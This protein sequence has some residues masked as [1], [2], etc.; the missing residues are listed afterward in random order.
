MNIMRKICQIF[1]NWTRQACA[2]LGLTLLLLMSVSGSA[3]AIDFGLERMLSPGELSEAHKKFDGDCKACHSSFKDQNQNPLCLDCHKEV[4]ADLKNNLG[5]HA[6]KPGI[7]TSECRLCHSEH[8]GRNADIVQL[9][10][11]VFDHGSTDFQLLGHHQGVPCNQCHDKEKKFSEA[12]GQCVDC[13]KSDDI[14][15]G[16]QGD[17]CGDCHSAMAWREVVFDHQKTKFP[18]LG[19]HEKASCGQCHHSADFTQAQ[20]DCASCHRIDDVHSNGFGEKCESCHAT[21]K[22][23]EHKFNHKRDTKFE[24]QGARKTLSCE[25]C[26]TPGVAA[27]HAPTTCSACHKNDDPHF[28]KNGDRCDQ[29]HDNNRW[30]KTVFNH[31]DFDFPLRGAHKQV[32]CGQCHK[33]DVNAPIADK[34][35]YD[36]H[37]SND[38][39]KKSLGTDCQQCHSEGSWNGDIRFVHDL[40]DFPL[41]GMHAVQAC[42]S[43]HIDFVFAGIGKKCADCHG[44]NDPHK[45]NLGQECANCH[46][47]VSWRSWR[48]DHDTQSEF[49]LHGAHKNVSCGSCHSQKLDTLKGTAPLCGSCHKAD[50]EHRG[51]YGERCDRCH[52]TSTF[53]EVEMR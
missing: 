26:H 30:G 6:K 20:T 11:A 50:D 44:A 14:H 13:H 19:M 42:E 3:L 32:A 49:P 47:P 25:S 18:L 35:C 37:Q 33:G 15:K 39:H 17:S 2:P 16:G 34:T 53:T 52:N 5:F 31:A 4:A 46:H 8:R 10:S 41:L 40:T 1:C 23:T 48:F 24:L 7:A 28:G 22:W 36:C 51:A 9:N 43:C 21:Q 45:G 29:C 38:V 27:K 12:P